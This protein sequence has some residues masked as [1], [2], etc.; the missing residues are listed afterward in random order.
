MN[1]HGIE[2]A[3]AVLGRKIAG[4]IQEKYNTSLSD[5]AA[6]GILDDWFDGLKKLPGKV[7]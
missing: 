5:S 7:F 2:K 3:Y 1:H 4:E 6:I